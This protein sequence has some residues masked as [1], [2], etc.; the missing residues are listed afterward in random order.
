[1]ITQ[2]PF[3]ETKSKALYEYTASIHKFLSDLKKT[4]LLKK[5]LNFFLWQNSN[6]RYPT[7]KSDSYIEAYKNESKIDLHDLIKL[8]FSK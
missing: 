1:M 8:Y 6:G 2:T 5:D 7:C 3:L 4:G